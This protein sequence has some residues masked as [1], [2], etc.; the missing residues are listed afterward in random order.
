MD[1]S[2]LIETYPRRRPPLTPEHQR[3]YVEQYRLNRE[4][5]RPMENLAQRL[6]SWMHRRVAAVGGGPILE[7]GAGTLNHRQYEPVDIE[8]DI[9]EPFQELYMGRPESRRVRASF[10]RVEDVPAQAVYRRIFS[11]AVLEHM[12]NL[13]REVAGAALRL[14]PAGVFQAGIPSEGGMLWGFA[15]RFSTGIS[16]YL[17]T[18]LDYGVVMRHEHLNTAAEIV[19]VVR[20]LFRDV[21]LSRFPL[22]LHHLSFYSY[23]EARDPDVTRCRTLLTAS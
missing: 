7:L 13:P 16:Y 3:V 17:R 18:G 23:I 12:E 10:G 2:R 4:G 5:A 11:I 15:W 6:E 9:V 19:A 22:P 1:A 14:G 8:Y 20:H 21:R